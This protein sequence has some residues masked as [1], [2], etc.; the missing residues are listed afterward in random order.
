MPGFSG[1]IGRTQGMFKAVKTYDSTMLETR[2]TFAAHLSKSQAV[3]HQVK[4]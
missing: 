4:L 3:Q 1:E 2:I